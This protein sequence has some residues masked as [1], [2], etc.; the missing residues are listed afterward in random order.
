M[1]AVPPLVR[2]LQFRG[3]LRDAY[4]VAT[5][6]THGYSPMVMYD[7]AR[8][9]MVPLDS[10]RSEF[11]RILGLAPKTTLVRLY[12]W[13]VERG[14]TG[15]IQTYIDVFANRLANRNYDGAALATH[16]A[17]LAAGRAYLALARRD[18]ALAL[19]LLLTSA[20]TLHPCQ[21][22]TRETLVDLLIASGHSRVAAQRL[23]RRWP[24]TSECSDG[25]DDILWTLKRA[26]LSERLGRRE[27]AAADFQLVATAW[28]T[29]D[30]ELQPYVREAQSALARLRVKVPAPAPNAATD[31]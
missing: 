1:C 17:S 8:F 24:G 31:R 21:Y 7:L 22:Q 19:E 18:T 25:V 26:R 5:L 3:H 4:R 28:R 16:R 12:P 9:G 30:P 14:D 6:T 13:W 29:A 11:D 23:Q 20:D 2:A 15:A 10:A 27:S